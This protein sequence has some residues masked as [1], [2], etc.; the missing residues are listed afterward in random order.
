MALD[1]TRPGRRGPTVSGCGACPSP[2]AGP[3]SDQTNS[4]GARLPAPLC[5]GEF[6]YQPLATNGTVRRYG[7]TAAPEQSADLC[8]AD[9]PGPFTLQLTPF[10]VAPRQ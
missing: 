7:A 10:T 5:F 6:C 9:A 4:R 3:G 8:Q 1:R 2:H